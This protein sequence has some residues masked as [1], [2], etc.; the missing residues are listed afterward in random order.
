MG[1]LNVN[2]LFGRDECDTD[3]LVMVCEAFRAA[4]EQRPG[5]HTSRKNGSRQ[6]TLKLDHMA[7]ATASTTIRVGSPIT[8]VWRL[9]WIRW[10]VPAMETHS[11]I[12]TSLHFTQSICRGWRCTVLSTP[13]VRAAATGVLT[14]TYSL[15]PQL[16]PS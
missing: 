5:P 13:R 2:G 10:T 14:G 7:C 3:T 1:S 9:L 16:K 8:D 15:N 6:A 12:I 11:Y 4:H